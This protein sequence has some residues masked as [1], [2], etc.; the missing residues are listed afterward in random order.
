[1]HAHII[2][3]LAFANSIFSGL[4]FFPQAIQVFITRQAE[5][6]SAITFVVVFANSVIWLAYALHRG[7]VSLVISSVLNVLAV[8]LLLVALFLFS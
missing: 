2:D 4:S 6:L 7:L 5:G 8:T 1:M 3:K